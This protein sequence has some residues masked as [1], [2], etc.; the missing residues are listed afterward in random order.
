M[1]A[2]TYIIKCKIITF[3]SPIST[4][5]EKR[6]DNFIRLDITAQLPVFTFSQEVLDFDDFE[7][8]QNTATSLPALN[9][10]A[11]YVSRWTRGIEYRLLP[12]AAALYIGDFRRDR[13]FRASSYSANVA[14]YREG[15][16]S[17][18]T[19]KCCTLMSSSKEDS[20]VRLLLQ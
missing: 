10:M 9:K 7:Q 12:T 11:S 18:A 2:I 8:T 14:A 3:W 1:A 19:L 15:G 6:W 17:F 16:N 13:I 20:V 5:V 4:A